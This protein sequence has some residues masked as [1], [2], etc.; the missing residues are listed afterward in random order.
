MPGFLFLLKWLVSGPQEVALSGMPPRLRACHKLFRGEGK[1][2]GREEITCRIGHLVANIDAGWLSKRLLPGLRSKGGPVTVD[3]ET[4]GF[5]RKNW[6]GRP[7]RRPLTQWP[8]KIQRAY[9]LRRP[10]CFKQRPIS[11]AELE[12]LKLSEGRKVHENGLF[13]HTICYA[14]Y[15]RRKLSDCF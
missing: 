9:F 8:T 5:L 4:A 7:V 11:A 13:P 2:G 12:Q 15:I 6:I 3:S 1:I 10:A 14:Q